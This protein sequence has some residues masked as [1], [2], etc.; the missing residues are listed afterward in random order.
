MG[1]VRVQRRR[2]HWPG[3]VTWRSLYQVPCSYLTEDQLRP[4]QKRPEEEATECNSPV[5]S[6]VCTAVLC[7]VQPGRVTKHSTPSAPLPDALETLAAAPVSA[8][9]DANVM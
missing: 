7:K 6:A 3:Y 9:T 8:D 2:R 1:C 4:R 5:P